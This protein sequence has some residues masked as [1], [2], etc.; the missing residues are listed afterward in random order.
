[1][2]IKTVEQSVVGFFEKEAADFSRLLTK[3]NAALASANPEIQSA[4]T[5]GSGIIAYI[6]NNLNSPAGELLTGI[7]AKFGVTSNELKSSLLTVNNID[8]FLSTEA[9]TNPTVEDLI[10]AGQQLL[11]SESAGTSEWEKI[12]SVAAQAIAAFFVPAATPY[13][14]IVSLIEITYQEVVKPLLGLS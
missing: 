8:K 2:S 13:S 12:A 6:S 10:T 7:T 5:K 9:A 4:L 3:A 11:S 1:M 14:I